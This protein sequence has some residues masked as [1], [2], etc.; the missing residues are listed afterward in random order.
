MTIRA[1]EEYKLLTVAM[2][3]LQ[4]RDREDSDTVDGLVSALDPLWYQM[5]AQER[6][7]S[8]H[9]AVALNAM[10]DENGKLIL[11]LDWE[12]LDA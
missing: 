11:P 5:D 3:L 7:L 12:K 8:K 6:V 1:L 10:K 9:F 4:E 2:V